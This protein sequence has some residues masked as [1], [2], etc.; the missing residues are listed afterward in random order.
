V[1][2]FSL[3]LVARAKTSSTVEA[4]FLLLSHFVVPVLEHTDWVPTIAYNGK[5]EEFS[6]TGRAPPLK[7]I[8]C[9]LIHNTNP[10]CALKR[11]F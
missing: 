9:E 5:I 4:D 1:R 7:E 10:A 2:A 3:L 6:H 11:R 8:L